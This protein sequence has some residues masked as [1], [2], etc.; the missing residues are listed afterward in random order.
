V[1][2]CYKTVC[3]AIVIVRE[4]ELVAVSGQGLAR[5]LGVAQKVLAVELAGSLGLRLK[6]VRSNYFVV[7]PNA[8]SITGRLLR[9][10]SA[11]CCTWL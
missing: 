4:K 11:L 3:R 9:N 10:I 8:D 1:N 7:W 6:V 2:I 5:Q